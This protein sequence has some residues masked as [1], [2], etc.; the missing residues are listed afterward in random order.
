VS[1]VLAA[2]VATFVLLSVAAGLPA[3]ALMRLLER[4]RW[5]G[6]SIPWALSI[7]LPLVVALA[8]CV[9]LFAPTPFSGCHCIPHDHHPHV[10]FSHP[11]LSA[12]LLL[13]SLLVVAIWL[14]S[15]GPGLLR[16]V[17][18]SATALRQVRAV[19]RLPAESFEGTV[20]R[21]TDCGGPA[22]FTAGL[23]APVIVLDRN[24]WDTL[25]ARERRAVLAHE[26]AHAERGDPLTGLVLRAALALQ[27][28]L[29][30]EAL[31]R[32]GHAT[33]LHCDRHAA[34]LLGD[35]AEVAEALVAVRR[36][37][38]GTNALAAAAL[39]GGSGGSDL[40]ARI[41]ALLDARSTA[42]PG[43]DVVAILLPTLGTLALVLVWPGD[44]LHHAFETL[45]GWAHH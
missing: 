10:C 30:E 22:A 28:W 34:D 5:A 27:P 26:R 40:E 29:P 17:L 2:S 6:R 41:H 37:S 14:A 31:G 32:W 23:H 42:S 8:I 24:V 4:S 7:L 36:M 1:D 9:A 12:P 33:E 44:A 39:L 43:N 3:V 38:A 35:G 13:P 25:D 18:A 16:I 45:I 11:A 21:F 15:T 20:V 19:K